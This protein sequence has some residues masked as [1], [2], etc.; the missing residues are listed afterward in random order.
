MP[1]S[2]L[3]A[4]P[5]YLAPPATYA[6][7]SGSIVPRPIGFI[8]TISDEGVANLAPFSFFNAVC[9]NPPTLCVSITNRVPP[10]DT[11]LNMRSNGEFVVNIVTEAIAKQMNLCSGEY[12]HGMSEFDVSKLTQ[13]TSAAVRPPC[14]LESPM[15]MEC[16]V[17]QI[18]DVSTR[19]GGASL[20]IGEILRFHYDPSI[21]E[22]LRIDQA[23]LRAVGRMG[24]NEY[25]RTRDRFEMIR[26]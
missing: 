16:R 17:V 11:I 21:M 22:G 4:D 6:L 12:P 2:K 23:K 24:G 13:E 3:L 8:S 18:V 26:P 5:A 15:N 14:V 19:P 25:T 10:K 7:M 20:V 1:S 9:A